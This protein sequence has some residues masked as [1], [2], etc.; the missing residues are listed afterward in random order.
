MLS[1]INENSGAALQYGIDKKFAKESKYVVFY[2]MG[3]S[4]TY[5]AL[6]YFSA[7]DTE[8]YGKTVSAN[9]FQV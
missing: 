2:D 6:V 7:Y 4:S 8:E 1:L 3:A 9:Q 5:A